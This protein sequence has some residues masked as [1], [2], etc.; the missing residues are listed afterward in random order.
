VVPPG[1]GDEA[2][3]RFRVLAEAEIAAH[4]TRIAEKD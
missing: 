3:G 1:D 2:G 4:L